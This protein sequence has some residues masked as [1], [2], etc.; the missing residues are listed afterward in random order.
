MATNTTERTREFMRYFNSNYGWFEDLTGVPASKW[1]DLDR[2]KT[3][4]VTAEMI[5]A[6]GKSWPEYVFWL[7]TGVPSTPRGQCTPSEYLDLT[8]GTVRALEHGARRFWRNEQGVLCPGEMSS[9]H[10]EESIKH[11]I[12][13]AAGFLYFSAVVNESEAAR[14]AEQFQH[15]FFNP[16]KAGEETVI[17]LG[18]LKNWV[19]QFPL[20]LE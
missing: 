16:L 11:E 2:G 19:N 17:A 12:A 10:P 7:V 6:F 13:I 15:Q 1:R 5:D 20:M 3:K 18:D 4:A 14:L 9:G 8:Y